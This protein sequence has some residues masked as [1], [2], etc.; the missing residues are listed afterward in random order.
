M[1]NVHL[2]YG[3]NMTFPVNLGAPYEE[4][5]DKLIKKGYAGTKSEAIRQALAFYDRYLEDE[6]FL[7][8]SRASKAMM[9]DVKSGKT[10]TY[11]LEDVL[12]EEKK[13]R[14]LR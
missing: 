1:F 3:G 9:D 10:R 8:V 2:L 11:K 7:L 4:I 5:M 13:R 6:E 14:G 12:N